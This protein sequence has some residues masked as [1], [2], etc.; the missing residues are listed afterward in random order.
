MACRQSLTALPIELQQ[1][2]FYDALG[3]GQVTV[4]FSEDGHLLTRSCPLLRV[5]TTLRLNI[6]ECCRHDQLH[7][8]Y[9]FNT[10]ESLSSQY[11]IVEKVV[12]APLRSIRLRLLPDLPVHLSVRDMPFFEG[13]LDSWQEAVASLPKS[14]PTRRVYVDITNTQ[15]L[16]RVPLAAVLHSITY[17]LH[18]KSGGQATS[19]LEK[20][21]TATLEPGKISSNGNA[22]YKHSRPDDIMGRLRDS[23]LA[24]IGP[25]KLGNSST[26]NLQ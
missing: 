8:V 23:R 10:P 26:R 3:A 11:S 15:I 19:R 16:P 13:I 12:G 1:Q 20:R 21:S 25:W 14:S 6:L 2:I 7:F 22:S 5:C 17:A 4:E 24:N 9:A 18:Q